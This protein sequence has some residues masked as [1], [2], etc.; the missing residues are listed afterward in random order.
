MFT[1]LIKKK[2]IL[3]EVYGIL[4]V[5]KHIILFVLIW[6]SKK[7]SLLLFFSKAAALWIK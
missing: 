1:I 5:S 3:T 7:Q 2:L 4:V 6:S